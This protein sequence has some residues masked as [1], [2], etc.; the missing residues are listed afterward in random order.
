MSIAGNLF[1]IA[2]LIV[3]LFY[4]SSSLEPV[5]F[6]FNLDSVQCYILKTILMT[7]TGLTGRFIVISTLKDVTLWFINIVIAKCVDDFTSFVSRP[8]T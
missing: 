1:S 3:M 7:D 6:N 8:F 5:K 2:Y 4:T